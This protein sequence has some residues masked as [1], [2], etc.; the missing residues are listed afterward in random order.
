M[1]GSSSVKLILEQG[2]NDEDDFGHREMMNGYKLI[3]KYELR[4]LI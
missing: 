3:K 2:R 4:D 1:G